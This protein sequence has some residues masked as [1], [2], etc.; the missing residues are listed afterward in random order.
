MSTR[1]PARKAAKPASSSTKATPTQARPDVLVPPALPTFLTGKCGLV[2]RVLLLVFLFITPFLYDLAVPEVSGDIRWNANIL[3]SGLLAFIL[4]FS[5]RRFE[6]NV[7]VRLPL[8]FWCAGILALWAGL[9]LIDSFNIYRG[10]WSIKALYAQLILMV[11]VAFTW[12][13]GFTMRVVWALI[14]PLAFTSWLGVLQFFG[15]G[16]MTFA[17]TLKATTGL[18]WMGNIWPQNGLFDPVWVGSLEQQGGLTGWLASWLPTSGPWNM[19]LGYYQSSAIPGSSFANKNL[20]GSYT[21]ILI[22][23]TL[24]ALL[25]ARR[26]WHKFAAS[27]LLALSSLFLLYSRARASW[28]AVFV[29]FVFLALVLVFVPEW[30]AAVKA[31]LTRGF[32]LACA[33]ALIVIALFGHATSPISA[34]GI[35]ISPTQQIENLYQASWNEV[36]GRVAYNLNGL[37]IVADHWFNGTGLGSFHAVYPGYH[38]ALIETVEN[39]YSVIARPQR[40]HN[41]LMQMFTETGL[42]GGSAFLGMFLCGLWMAWRLRTLTTRDDLPEGERLFPL[43]AG[44]S[45]VILGINALMDFPLQ[46]PTAPIV[47]MALLGVLAAIYRAYLPDFAFMPGGIKHWRVRISPLRTLILMQA[48]VLLTG[49]ALVDSYFFREENK[50]LKVAMARTMGGVVDDTTKAAIDKAMEIYPLDPRAHE[51]YGVIYSNFAGGAPVP[52]EKKIEV[53]E[54]VLK[55]DPWAP[56][57]LINLSGQY[58]T[59]AELAQQR[60]DF[61]A[62]GSYLSKVDALLPRL[63][64][65]AGDSYFYHGILGMRQLMGRQLD[66]AEASFNKA[67]QL[68]PDYAP[69]VNGLKVIQALRSR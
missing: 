12:R 57:H 37:M 66:Q 44:T 45:L 49:V 10:I 47:V 32:W 42:V 31:R 24:F 55:T 14:I 33:P 52:A 18:A 13:P 11:V 25:V 17:N 38:N 27:L 68:K 41:D 67:I 35:N 29:G 59:Q 9:S 4:L 3:A 5:I 46:L 58:L 19:L 64:R 30:R 39:S 28:V 51:Y 23:L 53:L 20:A 40:S 6:G 34:H 7:R 43:A 69:A 61:I 1:K 56:N 60:G 65:S 8:I 48:T 62:A 54:W 2:A 26:E 15:W 63:Q 36:G 16:D 50:Y 21:A 22:P